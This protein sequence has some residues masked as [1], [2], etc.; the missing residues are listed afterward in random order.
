MSGPT[1]A[2]DEVLVTTE[3]QEPDEDESPPLS[4]SKR[5]PEALPVGASKAKKTQDNYR[6]ELKYINLFLEEKGLPK[7]E[8][9]THKDVEADH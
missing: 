8:D 7:F 4:P 5:T 9:L 6:I 3:S 1:D 2:T